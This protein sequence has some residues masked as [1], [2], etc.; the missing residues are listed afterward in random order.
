MCCSGFVNL[1]RRHRLLKRSIGT[2]A[3]A[4]SLLNCPSKPSAKPPSLLNR[5]LSAGR[6]GLVER[7]TKETKV[8]VKINLDGSGKAHNKTGVPFLNHMLDQLSAHGLFD[9]D[10]AAEVSRP[11]WEEHA[12]DA[13]KAARQ[14]CSLYPLV[15]NA[16]RSTLAYA[17]RHV[18]R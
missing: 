6:T 8:S 10:V 7:S 3:W 17:G 12:F 18:D 11:W 9:L 1:L 2:P 14:T 16:A 5:P 15:L 4:H 13:S